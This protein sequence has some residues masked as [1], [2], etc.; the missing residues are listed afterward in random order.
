[1]AGEV[2]LA[3][4]FGTP[5]TKQTFLDIERDFAS[6]RAAADAIADPKQKAS[7]LKELNARE[8]RDKRDLEA[9]RDML[10]GTYLAGQNSTPFA[11]AVT[12]V[13]AFNYMRALGGVTLSPLS[14]IARPMMIHGLGRYM[15]AGVK[16]LLTNLKAVKMSVA[17]ARKLGAVVERIH[18]SRL[19]S[20]AEITDPYAMNSPFERFVENAARGFSIATGLVHWNDFQKAL[21]S[22]M[23]QDR[24]LENAAG[25]AKASK[26]ERAYVD[27][28]IVTKGIGD[29]MLW[30]HTPA[31]RVMSQFKGFSLASH[32]KAFMRGLQGAELGVDGGASGVLA[33]MITS[34]AVGALIY[35]LKSVESNRQDDVSDNPGR[36]IAEGL[37]RSGL[38]SVLFEINNTIEKGLGIGAY[39]A[40]QSLFPDRNQSGKASRYMTR[41]VAGALTGPTGDLVDTLVRILSGAK[42][43]K[44]TEGDVN[45]IFNILPGSKLPAIRSLMEYGV[46]PA[47]KDAVVQ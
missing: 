18:N 13:N 26:Q 16:P 5:D 38:F 30:A 9:L 21:A 40:F 35:W 36:W 44:L 29:T 37:D 31:G 23:T 28:T 8:K 34:T 32:Q 14:D 15:N 22:M 12:V 47:V 43:G 11:R 3:R 27:S 10:R 42:D 6:R 45:A 24:L 39:G 41:S 1:M 33:G 4:K 46:K 2:E 17:E 7:V 20:M 25:F 19:A